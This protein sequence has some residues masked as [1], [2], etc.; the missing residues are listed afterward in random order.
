MSNIHLIILA[1]RLIL[2]YSSEACI[3]PE[4]HVHFVATDV[5]FL[6]SLVSSELRIGEW[7]GI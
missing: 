6:T 1:A 5:L 2:S 3:K 4:L 7:G